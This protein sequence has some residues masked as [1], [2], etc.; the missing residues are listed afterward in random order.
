M[1]CSSL[2]LISRKPDGRSLN[3]ALY[4]SSTNFFCSRKGSLEE[5]TASFSLNAEVRS[6]QMVRRHSL[7]F[8]LRIFF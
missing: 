5:G 3:W 1:L 2:P 7:M 6:P 8:P 4:I